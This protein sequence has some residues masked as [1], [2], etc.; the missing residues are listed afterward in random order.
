MNTLHGAGLAMTLRKLSERAT[1]RVWIVSPYIGRWPAVSALLGGTWWL[2]ST[3]TLQVITDVSE[4][5]N[6]HRGTL[7]RLLNR[8]LVKTLPGVHAKIY[9]VDDQ[10]IVTSANLTQTTF[11]KRREIVVLLEGREATDTIGLFKTCWD[12]L[13]QELAPESISQLEMEKPSDFGHETDGTG[14]PIH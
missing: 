9:I 4:A 3:V 7:L 14:L 11:T 1:Q 5:G 10:A 8:G 2:G 13:A 6:V 12:T